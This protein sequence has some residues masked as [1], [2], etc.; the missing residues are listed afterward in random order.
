M[1]TH[2]ENRNKRLVKE[3]SSKT[4]LY[5]ML[6]FLAIITIGPFVMM[7]SASL[8]S[9]TFLTF[10]FDIIPEVF[11]LESYR[12]LFNQTLMGRW[13]L[14]SVIITTVTTVLVLATSAMAGFAF[15]RGEFPGRDLLFW[16]FMGT[17]MVPGTVTIVPLF[18]LL[19]RLGWIDSYA[20]LIVPHAMSIFGIFLMRQHFMTIPRDY[21][22]AV[23]IDGGSVWDIFWRVM[24]PLS[25]P[26]L[27]TLATI[28]FLSTWNAFLYPLIM[29]TTS[30]MR[31]LTVG[32]ATMVVQRGQAGLQMAGATVVFL[33]TFIFFLIMQRHV[34][35][36]LAS[37]GIK[38]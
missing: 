37:T 32:L 14:N 17:L 3:I 38:G 6:L 28:D 35:Q 30:E 25:K 9:M 24:L 21:D 12:L 18:L 19:S 20:G 31:P 5:I 22:D 4:I 13:M 1:S 7:I 23:R 15:A 33:P 10:P 34:V 16:V 11:S 27:A 36:G 2:T 8:Q 29:T 26:T